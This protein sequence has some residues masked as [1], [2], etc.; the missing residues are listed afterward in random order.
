MTILTS[1]PSEATADRY[2]RRIATR[3]SAG[4]P[5]IGHDI[6]ERLRVARQQAVAARR[7]SILFS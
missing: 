4:E 7:T 2:A 5:S 6:S 1:S 3:L